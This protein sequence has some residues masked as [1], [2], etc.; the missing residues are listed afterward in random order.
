MTL[1]NE[2]IVVHEVVKPSGPDREAPH[3]LPRLH[4]LLVVRDVPKLHEV[5]DPIAEH[6]RV[7]AQ[8]LVPLQRR[9][10]R[11]RDTP[12]PYS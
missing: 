4:Q 12:D 8:I 5:H 9:Q 2:R 1:T 11:I 10:Y 3:Q 6:L 7:D